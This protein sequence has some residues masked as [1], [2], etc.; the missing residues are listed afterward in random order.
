MSSSC[1]LCKRIGLSTCDNCVSCKNQPQEL[2]AGINTTEPI[3]SVLDKEF[4][5][6]DS[7]MR[8]ALKGKT[9]VQ[10][11][12]DCTQQLN[13][14]SEIIECFRKYG[15]NPDIQFLG[16]R[17]N[18]PL[19]G[20][21]AIDK[22]IN[23]DDFILSFEK[24]CGQKPI[25]IDENILIQEGAKWFMEKRAT[26]F[27]NPTTMKL[28]YFAI[29]FSAITGIALIGYGI[30]QNYDSQ[31]RKEKINEKIRQLMN[32][33]VTQPNDQNQQIQNALIFAQINQ[34]NKEL[35]NQPNGNGIISAGTSFV[36]AAAGAAIGTAIFPGVGTAIGWLAGGL[37]G[38]G[39]GPK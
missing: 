33:L 26:A 38:H 27:A 19:G 23:P 4:G 36:G 9:V 1:K 7:E 30:Y 29:G 20:L 39:V 11:I 16:L 6:I 31:Q 35:N 3:E 22:I 24:L 12:D 21:L 13:K 37:F 17:R 28:C 32:Q 2:G 8:N 10:I 5:S 15:K 18:S 14:S 25:A 34:L